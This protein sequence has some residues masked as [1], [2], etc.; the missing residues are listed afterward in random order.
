MEELLA[1]IGR[2]QAFSQYTKHDISHVD[3]MLRSLTWLIPAETQDLM[4]PAD[5]LLVV[6]SVYFHDL[7]MIVTRR[8]YE[9]REESAFP[10]YR[11]RVFS[12]ASGADYRGKVESLDTE[13]QERFL[14]QEFV[15]EH[16]AAR[17]RRWITGK[18]SQ[19][20]GVAT[21]A[22]D[23][24][25]S[26]V[27]A[28]PAPFVRDLAIVCES[29]H[30]DDLD[31]Y[32]KYPLSQPYGSEVSETA[33]VH[34]AALVLRVADLLHITTDRTPAIAFRLIDPTDPVSQEEWAK[35]AAVRNIR[36]KVPIAD[37]DLSDRPEKQ[38][39]IEVHAYFQSEEGFFGLTQYLAYARSQLRK[40]HEWNRRAVR[41]GGTHILPWRVIDD[42]G[43]ET[44]GFLRE[45]FSFDL[46]Q[47]K[48]LDLLTG[49]TLYNDTSVVVRELVQNSIDAIRLQKLQSGQAVDAHGGRVDIT[50]DS[51]GRVLTIWD[52][53]T[54]MTQDV[55]ENHLL[56][57]GSSRYQDPQFQ[58]DHPNFSP[59]SR[60]G[61][62]VLSTFMIADSVEIVTCAVDDDEARR[63]SLRSVHGRYL[64]RL[65][66]K[67]TDPTVA[68]IGPHGT[69]IRLTVRQS[70]EIENVVN[71]ARRW[72]VLPGCDVNVTIDADEP[73]RIGHETLTDALRDEMS[74]FSESVV[75]RGEFR[76]IEGSHGAVSFAA[77]V[78]W[79]AYFRDWSFIAVEP[80]P[81]ELADVQLGTC[82][83][84]IRVETGTPGFEDIGIIAI[85]NASG[86]AAPKTNVARSGIESTP[87]RDALLASVYTLYC[88]HISHE[89][90]ALTGERGFSDTW[91]ANEA[92]YLVS[93]LL[94]SPYRPYQNATP[95][96]A[97][98]LNDQ[99]VEIRAVLVE[100]EGRRER[101]SP[102]T[103]EAA[104]AFWVVYSA[105]FASA[106]ALLREVPSAAS[107]ASVVAALGDPDI[108]LPSD[109]PVLARSTWR[110]TS[111]ETLDDAAF[112]GKAVREIVIKRSERRLDLKWERYDGDAWLGLV[113]I[114]RRVGT[115]AMRDRLFIATE[116]V[117]LTG[118]DEEV[119]VRAGGDTYL[120]GP[121]E[122]LRALRHAIEEARRLPTRQ[123]RQV[124]EAALS[125]IISRYVSGWFAER[126][127]IEGW[128]EELLV[129]V[130]PTRVI[131]IVSNA[132]T[133]ARLEA[134]FGDQAPA[135]FNTQLWRRA[136]PS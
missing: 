59:I 135:V 17:I 6:L 130:T 118:V 85:A 7:G 37:D 26:L 13:A 78:R 3:A 133:P 63:L 30:L 72:I 76:V 87:E 136:E 62:G 25:A 93:P 80:E 45:I 40:A 126:D 58:E 18:P 123:L 64:I 48:I 112:R 129:T 103:L 32:R 100:R 92:N 21:D 106:E 122:V 12:G 53:G 83:E 97:E 70:A 99:L 41:R 51:Q 55:I 19:E 49:H 113:V 11:E 46:D 94:P 132:I 73:V 39:A 54:G 8:E 24:V 71:A 116:P 2:D 27:D 114:D 96:D 20:L 101:V 4:T 43:I 60:F 44:E 102:R 69:M 16:H 88:D 107:L 117:R 10:A 79:N 28:L 108:Q 50:W 34:F 90:D 127:E 66:D 15:R 1:F 89:L 91:A 35:Q 5:W 33:N 95:S 47:T 38:D 42:S 36:A 104:E 61:I 65:L 22:A 56:K 120:F 52:D 124:A 111:L 121:E 86:R 77:A 75:G 23:E 134:A 131:S 82:I 29:H 109:G 81:G 128:V 115:G 31:N 119:A 125:A 57:V 68:R 105:L 110:P 67:A 84:G 74:Q 9:S 98:L 14:Y